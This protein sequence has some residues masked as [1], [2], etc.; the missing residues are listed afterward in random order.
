MQFF[1]WPAQCANHWSRGLE[2]SRPDTG[3]H[4]YGIC[5]SSPQFRPP[6]LTDDDDP[7]YT[8]TYEC[9]AFGRLSQKAIIGTFSPVSFSMS[10]LLALH[11]LVAVN[12]LGGQVGT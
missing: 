12:R 10:G 3:S 6:P 11:C 2:G 1:L 7:D 5:V 8:H 4:S 9:T